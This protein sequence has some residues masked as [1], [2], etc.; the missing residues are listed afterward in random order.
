MIWSRNDPGQAE[1]AIQAALDRMAELQAKRLSL[2]EL[3]AQLLEE[4]AFISRILAGLRPGIPWQEAGELLKNQC[5]RPFELSSL[6]LARADWA[7]GQ[8]HFPYFFE[9]GRP[10]QRESRELTIRPG[11]T[12]RVVELGVPLYLDSKEACMAEGMVL[13]EAELTTGLMNQTW[14]GLPLGGRDGRLAGVLAFQ[15]FHSDAFPPH[16]RRLMEAVAGITAL[17]LGSD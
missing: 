5:L 16:R 12:G 13:T 6:Y 7:T 4:R 2:A 10:R 9:A 1:A 17:H 3:Q 15:S 11:L 14:F 8:L